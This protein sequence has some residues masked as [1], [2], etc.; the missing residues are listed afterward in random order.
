M[1]GEYLSKFL[2]RVYHEIRERAIRQF[3]EI[4][5][6]ILLCGYDA[7]RSLVRE[8]KQ[9]NGTGSIDF[10]TFWRYNESTCEKINFYNVIL[11]GNNKWQEK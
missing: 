11:R 1:K 5:A 7:W 10:W 3:D 4:Y 6:A 9:K 2:T 8:N